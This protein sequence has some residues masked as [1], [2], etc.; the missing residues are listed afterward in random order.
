MGVT[1]HEYIILNGDK[2]ELKKVAKFFKNELK[3]NSDTK[4]YTDCV[5]KI[6]GGMNGHYS[7][8]IV[9]TGWNGGYSEQIMTDLNNKISRMNWKAD[10][11][12]DKHKEAIKKGFR[13][14]H[15]HISIAI[16]RFADWGDYLVKDGL[17]IK[18]SPD[19]EEKLSTL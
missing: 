14:H 4:P 5:G 2:K 3:K 10:K 19:K 16:L 1:N 12:N 9:P 18:I 15:W 7:L 8:V 13:R 17:N 11:Y 6:G